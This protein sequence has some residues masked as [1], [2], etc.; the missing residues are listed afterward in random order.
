MTP[1]SLPLAN[2]HC[3]TVADATNGSQRAQRERLLLILPVAIRQCPFAERPF[4]S[5]AKPVSDVSDQRVLKA[6]TVLDLYSS[7]GF[8]VV[9]GKEGLFGESGKCCVSRQKPLRSP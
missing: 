7:P 1:A 2:G 5:E 6:Y 4:A 9:D 8:S 3:R